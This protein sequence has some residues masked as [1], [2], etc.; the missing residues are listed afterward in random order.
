MNEKPLI[1]LNYFE[2]QCDDAIID[3][4]FLEILQLEQNNKIFWSH[5]D[6]NLGSTAGYLNEDG[7]KTYFNKKLFEWVSACFNEVSRKKYS[8]DIAV[9]DS[10]LT[11]AKFLASS[12]F[13]DHK[14]SVLSG[15]LYFDDSS[16]IE[17]RYDDLFYEHIKFYRDP[18]TFDHKYITSNIKPKKGNLIIFPSFVQ[19]RITPNKNKSHRYS[20]AFNTFFT[21]EISTMKTAR[22]SLDCK[23][24]FN[25]NCHKR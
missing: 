6:N 14:M 5:R 16:P 2:F 8:R 13:H 21:G 7:S 23:N 19:H 4:V 3:E 20:L 11:K 10:W 1:S 24:E 15:V 9:V 18:E 22:F 25:A 12:P 17:F